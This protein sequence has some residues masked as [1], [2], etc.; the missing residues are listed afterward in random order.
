MATELYGTTSCP[1][2]QELREWLEWKRREF[3]EYDVENDPDALT[4]MLTIT[5]GRRTVPVLVEDGHA[6]QIGWQGRGCVIHT[7]QS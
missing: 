6:V 5:G 4:R 2:T 7:P 1:Y 3:L